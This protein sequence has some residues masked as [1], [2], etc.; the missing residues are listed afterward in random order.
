MSNRSINLT[1]RQEAQ[2]NASSRTGGVSAPEWLARAAEKQLYLSEVYRLRA[3][4]LRELEMQG[5]EYTEEDVF[6]M[7]S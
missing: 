2:L 3:R 6:R 7:V 4:T 5:V 1:E